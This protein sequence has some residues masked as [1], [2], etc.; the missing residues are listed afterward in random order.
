[1]DVRTAQIPKLIAQLHDHGFVRGNPTNKA[2]IMQ[3]L[4]SRCATRPLFW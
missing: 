2:T 1:M 3:I 4:G